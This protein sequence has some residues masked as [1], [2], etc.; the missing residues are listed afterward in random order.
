MCQEMVLYKMMVLYIPYKKDKN[1]RF[2]TKFINLG[3]GLYKG[4]SYSLGGDNTIDN[5]VS[6]IEPSLSIINSVR[7][8]E[9]VS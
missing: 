4:G 7:D 8:G 3:L 9:R 6:L 2:C 1:R 5:T